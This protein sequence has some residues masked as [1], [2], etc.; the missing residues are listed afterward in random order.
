MDDNVL[1]GSGDCFLGLPN[2]SASSFSSSL[3]R[4]GK[5]ALT[6]ESGVLVAT[7]P[8]ATMSKNLLDAFPVFVGLA[9]SL[10]T[11]CSLERFL[12]TFFDEKMSS[13]SSSESAS[14][15]RSSIVDFGFVAGIEAKKKD[16]KKLESVAIYIYIRKHE[17]TY[18]L[19]L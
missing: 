1:A 5:S 12:M 18:Q 8:D 4:F 6:L 16:R 14:A 7:L 17:N 9:L 2:R 15:N 3:N 11:D 19:Y 10:P 13:E